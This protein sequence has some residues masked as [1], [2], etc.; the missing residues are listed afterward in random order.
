MCKQIVN[1]SYKVEQATIFLNISEEAE[2]ERKRESTRKFS[3]ITDFFITL[4]TEQDALKSRNK[5]FVYN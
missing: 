3:S 4:I 1:S 2:R 5:S